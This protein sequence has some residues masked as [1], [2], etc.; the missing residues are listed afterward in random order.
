MMVDLALGCATLGAAIEQVVNF[1]RII[2]D[3]LQIY[4][5]QRDDEFW[6]GVRLAQPELDPQGF[7]PDFWLLYLQRFFSWATD[8]LLPVKVVVCSATG[9]CNQNQR[10]VAFIR[11]DWVA[12][13]T[14][15]ALLISRKYWTLPIVRT[16][17]EWLENVDRLVFQGIITWPDGNEQYANQ[18]R[19][20]LLKALHLR[21]PPPRLQEIAQVLCLTVQTLHRHLQHEGTGYQRL[22]DELR[23]DFAID[24]LVRQHQSIAQVAQQLGFAEPRSFSRAFKQWTGQSPSDV[25]RS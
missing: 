11:E 12:S 14:N 15:D 19:A 3:D 6:L 21:T 7:L 10:L 20:L 17:S 1:F 25:R 9:K 4:C 22:L 2:G 5:E 18:V 23:R 13:E 16:R 8:L 24:L